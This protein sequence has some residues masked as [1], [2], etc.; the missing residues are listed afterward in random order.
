MLAVPEISVNR[1]FKRPER[2]KQ[3][4][5]QLLM[6]EENPKLAIENF[7]QRLMRIN[8]REKYDSFLH[9]GFRVIVRDENRSIE[10]TFALVEKELGLQR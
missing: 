3:F 7:R 10:E 2:E 4:L 6:E 5:Y 9:S 1:F 8:S